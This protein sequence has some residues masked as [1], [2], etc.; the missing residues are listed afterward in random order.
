MHRLYIW[1]L[2]SFNIICWC[3][4]LTRSMYLLCPVHKARIKIFT[5][6]RAYPVPMQELCLVEF[7]AGV[8]NTW[9]TV[10]A[11]SMS[12]VGVDLTYGNGQ[13][14]FDILTP[15]GLAYKPELLQILF[16]RCDWQ[17]SI[18]EDLANKC[19]CFQTQ[20]LLNIKPYIVKYCTHCHCAIERF[21]CALWELHFH[22][23]PS[24]IFWWRIWLMN[25]TG[26]IRMYVSKYLYI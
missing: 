13:D 26:L 12:A 11:D 6:S 20:P 8:G 23:Q 9:R 3:V 7:F 15:A 5:V 19:K 1:L 4:C 25:P 17:F 21:L 24:T 22:I 14:A 2:Q 10:R 18:S 16:N